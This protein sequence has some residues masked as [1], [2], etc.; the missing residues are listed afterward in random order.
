MAASEIHDHLI[1]SNAVGQTM[2][3]RVVTPPDYDPSRR[4]PVV[5]LLHLWGRD[6][7]Y[8][9]DRLSAHLKLEEGV[10][11]GTLPPMILAM[12]QGDKSFYLN[13]AD[14]PGVDWAG[15]LYFGTSE[16]F[17]RAL[18]LYGNYGDYLL[19][20]AI[21][22]V[23]QTYPVRTD[24]AGRA[25]GGLS[26]GAAGAA[27][28][29][30]TDPARFCAVGIHSPALFG[31]DFPGPPWIFGLNDPTAFALRD[32]ASVATR[33]VTSFNQPRIWLDCGWDD[34]MRERVDHL[35]RTLC[36]LNVAHDYHMRP[37]GHDGTYWRERVGD[38]LAFYAREWG[39]PAGEF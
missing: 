23:E 2:R 12:P 9:T 16:F 4:Y 13:A 28:H 22:F 25:I 10:A 14:P 19:K 15:S 31:D 29:A 7:R 21:P 11:A 26:Q 3:V 38:Y 1:P 17:H 8:W 20:E 35:H 5:Y 34:P 37:G 39:R 27:V 18:E 30:F 32:P 6:E 33:Y 24:R 36:G